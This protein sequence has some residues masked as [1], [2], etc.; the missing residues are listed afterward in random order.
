[1]PTHRLISH[2][3]NRAFW[4]I[5]VA[6]CSHTKLTGSQAAVWYGWREEVV[7]SWHEKFGAVSM[8]DHFTQFG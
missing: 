5:V 1:M 6:H 3:N 7:G 2:R 8:H 4:L